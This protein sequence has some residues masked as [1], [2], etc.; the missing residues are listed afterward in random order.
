M[1][2]DRSKI[3][4]RL[5]SKTEIEVELDQAL[6]QA[7][8]EKIELDGRESFFQLRNLWSKCII[9]WITLFIVFHIFI[10][11]AVGLGKLDFQSHVWLVPGIILE[12]FFQ[13]IGMGYIVVKF[14]YTPH[15][16]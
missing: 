15:T 11:L 4:S 16:K 6:L 14:F 2:S 3:L 7:R 13:V 5:K 1:V 10:T 8:K 9:T 12:N